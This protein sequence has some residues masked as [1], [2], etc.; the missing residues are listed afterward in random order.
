MEVQVRYPFNLDLEEYDMNNAIESA[1]CIR[2]F[3]I[4]KVK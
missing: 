3:M 1:N 2:D 4:D